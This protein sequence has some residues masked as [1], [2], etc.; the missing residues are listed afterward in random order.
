MIQS[1]SVGG[2]EKVLINLVNHFD[3]SQF[4]INVIALSNRNPLAREIY[5]DDIHFTPLPRKWRYDMRPAQ[6]I[7][8]IIIKN[9]I[10]TVIAFDLFS[11][12]YI[13]YAFL[14][15]PLKPRIYISLHSTTPKNLKHLLQSMLYVRLL[16]G[17]EK[18]ISVCDVQADYL[19]KLYGIPRERFTTIYNGVDVEYFHSSDEINVRNSIR[20]SQKIPEDAFV[21]LQ[22]A[23][24]APHK[25]HEDSLAALR[26]LVDRNPGL[27][28][29]LLFRDQKTGKISYRFWLKV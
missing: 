6:Q 27:A 12:F 3:R 13:W 4:I 18:F 5:S 8:Q 22:V 24:L 29:Y 26:N 9:Q 23:S 25:R 16:C 14:R 19:S 21:I 28:C 1:L 7:R 20:S 10:D 2:A 15:I 11:F 17:E